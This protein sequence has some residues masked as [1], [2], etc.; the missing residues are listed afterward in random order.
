MA[1]YITV[2]LLL[3]SAIVVSGYLI[4][5]AWRNQNASIGISIWFTRLSFALSGWSIAYMLELA[6]TRPYMKIFWSN[7]KFIA[8]A[9]TPVAW[10]VFCAYSTGQEKPFTRRRRWQLT[11]LPIITCVIIFTDSAHHLF[12][13]SQT[14]AQVDEILHIRVQN[15]IWFWVHAVYSYLLLTA[16]VVLLIRHLRR[17]P[18]LSR[19]RV[20]VLLLGLSVPWVANAITV[21][22]L[23]I[24]D[25]TPLGFVVTMCALAWGMLRFHLLNISPIARDALFDQI[26]DAILILD[27]QGR[28]IDV[29]DASRELLH[30]AEDDTLG[31]TLN[32]ALPKLTEAE[33]WI[34]EARRNNL[35]VHEWAANPD[36]SAEAIFD[37]RLSTLR[38]RNQQWVGYLITFRD[39]TQQKH[40][41]NQ[42][43]AKNS[44]LQQTNTD[45]ALAREKAEESSRLK[46]EFLSVMSHELRTP[47]N[48]IMGFTELQMMGATGQLSTN[49]QDFLNRT[50]SSANELLELINNV[51][52]LTRLEAERLPLEQQV[53][54]THEWWEGAIQVAQKQTSKRGLQFE[55]EIDPVLPETMVGDAPRLQQVLSI[56]LS[57]ALKFTEQGLIRVWMRHNAEMGWEIGVQDTGVGV[58]EHLHGAIFE[59]FRQ[60]DSSSRRKYGGMGLGLALAQRL[61][62]Q[63]GG[64]IELESSEGQGSTFRIILPLIPATEPIG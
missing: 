51:I 63:M 55:T 17:A 49:Q 36:T 26:T 52:D 31:K 7:L 34:N 53:F 61:I 24:I 6:E 41:E 23:T 5:L 54:S 1:V 39:I 3:L 64:R 37:V 42:I 25:L 38:N 18:S 45:L 14:L 15:G 32:K 12:R 19:E 33:Q 13:T 21:A 20:F 8:V 40:A 58:P 57:N 4:L 44:E 30:F 16:G 43:K 48:A 9:L 50:L 28:L 11:I 47:L 59:A 10:L 22:G 29:N 56:L 46:S 62:Q 27:A 60:A 35:A 2:Q